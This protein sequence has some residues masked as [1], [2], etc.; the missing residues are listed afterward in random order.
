M[1][2]FS[3][4]HQVGI[5]NNAVYQLASLADNDNR[6]LDWRKATTTPPNLRFKLDIDNGAYLTDVLSQASISAA[7]GLIVSDRIK[8]ILI[9]FNLTKHEYHNVDLEHSGDNTKYY[10]LNLIVEDIH[11]YVDYAKS[12]FYVTEFGFWE[13]NI[14]IISFEDLIS[15]EKALSMN[16]SIF[17]EQLVFKKAIAQNYDLFIVG[18]FSFKIYIS[19][20]LKDKLEIENITGIK[21]ESVDNVIFR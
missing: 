13:R 15:K 19:E 8:K 6:G 7:I 3:L 16:H 11:Q 1:K 20:R 10:W 9:D 12:K 18:Y 4:E 2:I 5:S 17:C 21:I 14:S